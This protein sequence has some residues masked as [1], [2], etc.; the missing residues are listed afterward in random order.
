V[1]A[2]HY[3]RP[4]G[5][6]DPSGAPRKWWLRLWSRFY[7]FMFEKKPGDVPSYDGNFQGATVNDPRYP[8][9]FNMPRADESGNEGEL[10]D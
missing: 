2:E 1:T 10:E 6:S 5:L 4:E 9:L 3:V 8:G 7:R